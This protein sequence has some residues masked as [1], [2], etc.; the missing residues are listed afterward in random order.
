VDGVTGVF[1]IFLSRTRIEA[2][3]PHEL[4][5]QLSAELYTAFLQIFTTTGLVKAKN[6]MNDSQIVMTKGKVL[7]DG[8]FCASAMWKI[9]LKNRPERLYGVEQDGK[10]IFSVC[11]S[12]S[13]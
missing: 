8:K 9:K 1:Q 11:A 7:H 3:L 6:K 4:K 10:I 2:I 12:K 5:E 13:R